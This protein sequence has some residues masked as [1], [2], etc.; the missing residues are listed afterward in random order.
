MKNVYL[1]AAL[2]WCATS[3]AGAAPQRAAQT[4]DLK[5]VVLKGEGAVNIIQQRTAVA[6]VI[7]VRDL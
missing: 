5:I 2:V 7:E 4:A 3:S 6:P 1:I